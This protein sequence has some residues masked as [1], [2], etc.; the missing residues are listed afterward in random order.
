MHL[1]SKILSVL[2]SGLGFLSGL[3]WLQ[4]TETSPSQLFSQTS[5]QEINVNPSD[6]IPERTITHFSQESEEASRW[7]NVD[8]NVMGGISQGELSITTQGTGWF[9]GTLSLENNGGFSSVR[10]DTSDYDFSNISSV[11]T[12]VKGDGRRYQLRIQTRDADSVTYRAIFETTADEWQTVSVDVEAFEPVFRGRVIESAPSLNAE[13][14]YQIG[15]L[16]ADKKSGDFSLE[17]DWIGV[18]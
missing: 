12:R 3:A 13:G 1:S 11:I 16:I 17:V 10:R 2:L 6:A 4:S 18:E 7:R 14:I 9:K 15:F 8:D 5:A